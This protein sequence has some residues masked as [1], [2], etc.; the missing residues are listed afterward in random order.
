MEFKT[1]PQE[2]T[3]NQIAAWLQELF[4]AFLVKREDAPVLV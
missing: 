2:E 3:Y 4:G 1:K